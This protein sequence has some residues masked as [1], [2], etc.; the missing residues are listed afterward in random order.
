MILN[1]Y[2]SNENFPN[3]DVYK[4]HI[5][6]DK[7]LYN[8]EIYES[9]AS[10]D[11]TVH[12][13]CDDYIKTC[14]GFVIVYAINSRTSFIEANNYRERIY[15]LR[16]IKENVHLPILFVGN[17]SDLEIQRTVDYVE[18][19]ALAIKWNVGLIESS[20]KTNQN[21]MALFQMICEDVVASTN[22]NTTVVIDKNTNSV[23]NEQQKYVLHKCCLV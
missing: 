16:N 21:I 13:M 19:K 22:N 4:I 5:H 6:I 2:G 12:Q 14:D 1:K 17:K 23:V 9:N 10:D 18:A 15:K 7:T 11:Y 8:T 3:F 20:T